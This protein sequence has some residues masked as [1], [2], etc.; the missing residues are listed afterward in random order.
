MGF[1]K[2]IKKDIKYY[3]NWK[4]YSIK[5][6]LLSI[7]IIISIIPMVFSQMFLYKLS[8]HYLEKKITNLT[9]RN[10]FYIKTNIETDTN[11]YKDTLYR[12]AADN[13]CL[14][15]EKMFND[16]NEFEKAASINKIRD[17]FGSYSYSRSQIRAITFVGKDGR[18]VYYDKS[19]QGINNRVWNIYSD[20]AKNEIYSE[21]SNSNTPVILPTTPNSYIG[22]K[23]EY[24]FHMGLRVRDIRTKNEMG[25]I[26]MSFD[27]QVLSD[28][29]N[30]GMDKENL[31]EDRINMC[32][33]I[34]NN[35]GRIISF[36]D[37]KYIGTYIK[38]YASTEIDGKEN[39]KTLN[40]LIYSIPSFTNRNISVN[41]IPIDS[42]GWKII[43]IVDKDNLFYEV[44]LLRNLTFAFL[45]IIVIIVMVVIIIFSNKFYQSVE[46]IVNGMKEAKK[47]NFNAKIELNTEDELAF[48]GDEFNEMLSTINILV[49][50]VK[51]QNRYIVELS[52]KRR[53][54][55]IKAIVAQ[56]N[57]HFLYNTL[58]CI[59]WMAIKN[60]NYE[61]SDTIGNFAQILRYSIGDI[62]K[63]VAIY[64]EVEW[65][66]KYVYL[67]QLRFNNSFILNLEVNESVLSYRIHKLILQPL[68]E[69]S[70]IHGFKG[71]NDGRN[72]NVSINKIQGNH[73]KII[74]NDNG[75]GIEKDK[76]EKIINNIKLEMDE[77]ENL[78]I[79]NVFDRIKIYYG[80]DAKFEIESVE[81]EGTTISLVIPL[82]T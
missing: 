67:Q 38:D 39:S 26:I 76:L 6:K 63:E 60:E 23:S 62:N 19:N 30:V 18:N 74:V 51:N 82:V 56:I 81:Q 80:E 33:I 40:Q 45:G 64:D 11:Y 78:G 9:D 16:G 1:L 47:G 71:Y 37:K 50:D 28:I 13:D 43:N 52:N 48:I 57:P 58:D 54:A 65:L 68:I 20:S 49:E 4:R 72:L 27:E 73:I 69:N 24:M 55:E 22:G 3:S 8:Q 46:I 44:N 77:D 66:K 41:S 14:D 36:E 12:I 42:V 61:V 53:E 5:A 79:K 34:V 21:I 7:F 75:N 70:I 10:L 2:K 17:A 59:N 29:C 15:L 35:D 25:I 32:S 31:P